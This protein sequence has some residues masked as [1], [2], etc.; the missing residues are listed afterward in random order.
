MP[1]AYS[2]SSAFLHSGGSSKPSS[3]T[4]G[5]ANPDVIDPWF[6]RPLIASRYPVG[7]EGTF[8]SCCPHFIHAGCKENY[9]K[10]RREQQ[11]ANRLHR[12]GRASTEFRCSLCRSVGNFDFPVVDT[13]P[14]SVPFD[15]LS[16]CLRHQIDLVAWLRNLHMWFNASPKLATSPNLKASTFE[17]VGHCLFELLFYIFRYSLNH[18]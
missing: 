16:H 2:S 12:M 15:W 1:S 11:D 4:I 17:E 8:L 14:N 6:P 10:R 13:F 7:E 9:V 5:P 18:I 3:S